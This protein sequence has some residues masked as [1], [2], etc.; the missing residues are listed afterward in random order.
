MYF[1]INYIVTL[2]H[3]DLSPGQQAERR[4]PGGLDTF[5]F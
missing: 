2:T 4:R 3:I 5:F 1:N